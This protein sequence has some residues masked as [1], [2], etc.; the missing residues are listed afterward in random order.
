MLRPHHHSPSPLQDRDHSPI[1]RRIAIAFAV[2]AVVVFAVAATIST[3]SA[4]ETYPV[5]DTATTSIYSLLAARG[6]LQLGSYS[7]F[8]WNHPG[9]LLYQVLAVPYAASGY[10]E[11]ALKWAALALNIGW[12]AGALCA[13]H[14]RSPGFAL[15]L[16]AA[17][18]P[19]LWREQRLLFLAWNPFVP[20]L[21]LLCG[22]CL[23][24]G[25][26]ARSRWGAGALAATLSFCV[27]AHVGL[28]PVCAVVAFGA[29]VVWARATKA[30]S[31]PWWRLPAPFIVVGVAAAVWMVPLIY[32]FRHW[33]GN[34]AATATFLLDRTHPHP[35]W[36]DSLNGA[37][38]ML[39]APLL[40]EWEAMFGEL[41]ARANVWH[42]VALSAMFAA[43]CAACIHHRARR[44]RYEAACA[45]ITAATLAVAPVAAHGIVGPMADY[46]LFWVL[47]VGVLAN[48]VIVA[49]LVDLWP[50]ASRGLSRP[51]PWAIWFVVAA[52]TAIGSFRL[53]GKHA[54]QAKDTTMRALASD[55][56]RY[57]AARG[58]TRPLVDFDPESWQELTGLVLQFAKADAPIAVSARAVHIVGPRFAETRREEATFYLMPVSGQLPQPYVEHV[59]WVATRGAVRV[60]RLVR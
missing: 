52:W 50:L 49:T 20:V 53:T 46:L 10:R 26:E 1:P 55:L 30:Q 22:V 29:A 23:A 14:R 21:A 44:N 3:R 42:G 59:E 45:A 35:H 39:V 9:P 60:V 58:V 13:A 18:A 47:A 7:R 41:P 38:Y 12:L 48:A 56:Q 24:A 15:A 40:P 28:G 4:P 2:A 34:L 11:I 32:E 54:D 27:Q 36:G 6:E 37:G 43:A 31:A 57:C 25:L 8:G 33:P 17:L 51:H 19:L 5:A 16:V